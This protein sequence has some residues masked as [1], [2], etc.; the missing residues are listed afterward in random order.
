[1]LFSITDSTESEDELRIFAL[2]TASTVTEPVVAVTVW[3]VALLIQAL[4]LLETR[5]LAKIPPAAVPSAPN[6]AELPTSLSPSLCS[7]SN[8][9]AP[10]VW[11]VLTALPTTAS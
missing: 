9:I 4:V 2:S 6:A 8:R 11:L 3:S 1:M 10:L 5:L 7:A